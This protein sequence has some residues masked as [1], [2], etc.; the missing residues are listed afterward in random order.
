[1]DR[2]E[3]FEIKYWGGDYYPVQTNVEKRSNKKKLLI[4]FCFIS[5]LAIIP[6]LIFG[7]SNLKLDQSEKVTVVKSEILEQKP[8]QKNSAI[9]Q[10]EPEVKKTEVL[11]NDSYWKISKR[12]CGSG[13]YYLSILD[14]NN[15]K[16][17]YKGD[18]AIVNCVL[19]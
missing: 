6:T 2:N 12:Y 14:Q 1:M 9:Q 10:T 7:L 3:N 19:N 15:G 5:I 16:A 4:V 8:Q 17:L 18:F 11:N 13:K